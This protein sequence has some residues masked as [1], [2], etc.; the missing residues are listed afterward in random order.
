MLAGF[1]CLRQLHFSWV[2][3]SE[4]GWEMLAGLPSLK[5]LTVIGEHLGTLKGE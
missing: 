5:D 1:P 2:P 4:A 3:V